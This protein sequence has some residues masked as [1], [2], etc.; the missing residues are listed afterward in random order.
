[1][2]ERNYRS[3]PMQRIVLLSIGQDGRLQ[4]INGSPVEDSKISLSVFHWP[5]LVDKHIPIVHDLPSDIHLYFLIISS[6]P[7]RNKDFP[8]TLWPEIIHK[9]SSISSIRDFSFRTSWSIARIRD[10]NW[11][12][13][14]SLR[15]ASCFCISLTWDWCI[16]GAR[17]PL[18]RSSFSLRI[19]FLAVLIKILH[20]TI[21]LSDIFTHPYC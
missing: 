17:Y 8:F 18:V 10:S 21:L 19:D 4:S 20:G 14:S 2:A 16:S 6:D 15:E 1:M 13:R 7:G 5:R 11:S 3:L 9:G 12:C